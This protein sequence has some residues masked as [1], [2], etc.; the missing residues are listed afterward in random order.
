MTGK[1]EKVSHKWR[2]S[3]KHRNDFLKDQIEIWE[4][5]NYNN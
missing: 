3:I 5:K 2:I 4:L 1:Y